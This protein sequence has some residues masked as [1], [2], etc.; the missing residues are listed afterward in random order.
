MGSRREAQDGSTGAHEEHMA[1]RSL[2]CI[3]EAQ[4]RGE[5]LA[6][7]AGVTDHPGAKHAG[8]H[9]IREDVEDGEWLDV[10]HRDLTERMKDEKNQNEMKN[11]GEE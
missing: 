3:L 7:T 5:N 1:Q 10:R 11:T 2:G 8:C 9:E 4:E 6:Y